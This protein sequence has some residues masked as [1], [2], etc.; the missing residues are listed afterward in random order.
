[1]TGRNTQN[2][3]VGTVVL[4]AL[5]VL[6]FGMA[7]LSEYHPG[8]SNE[9]YTFV[10][11]Q[12][13]L[14][15]EGDP[16]KFNGVKVGKV[17]EIML[18]RETKLVRIRAQVLA[19]VRIPQG[20]T[21]T[22][23]NVGLMGER[24][25]NIVLSASKEDV[26]PGSVL[27]AKYDYGIAE[28]MAAA[29]VV[30]EDARLVIV[31]L[32]KVMDSTVGRPEFPQR[33]HGMVNRADTVVRRLDRI[34][35][36]LEPRV[37]S[38]VSDLSAAGKSARS[39]AEKASPVVDRVA[40]RADRATAEME[41]MVQDLKAVSNDIRTLVAKAKN[42]ESTLGKLANDDKFYRELS[43]AVVR[44]DSLVHRIQKKGLD[45]NVDLW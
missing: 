12:V 14:L 10:A 43:S 11:K 41:P 21:V 20:S 19:G 36:D 7:F 22:I 5:F 13:G 39:M 26:K 3:I 42:G 17:T 4:V 33:F 35:A 45:I 2:V 27:E 40:D 29:G 23:Q 28:T 16:V 1:M 30:I 6:I 44:T 24:M 37:K 8:Q 15:S 34:V 32:R 18:D 9:E 25:I 38:A 31:D